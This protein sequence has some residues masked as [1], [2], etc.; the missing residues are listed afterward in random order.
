MKRRLCGYIAFILLLLS[1]TL[2]VPAIFV[3]SADT[4]APAVQWSKTYAGASATTVIQTSD[5]GY[6]IVS[7]PLIS[8]PDTVLEL[9][10]TDSSGNQVWLKTYPGFP[11]GVLAAQ[12]S[13]GGIA[14]AG[15]TS[16]SKLFLA[17]LDASGA[18]LWNTTFSDSDSDSFTRLILTGDGDFAI[19]GS[20]VNYD[21][22]SYSALLVKIDSGGNL[23]WN[24]TYG[25]T[26][27]ISPCGLSQTSDGGY[28][29]A[30]STQYFGFSLWLIKIDASGNTQWYMPFQGNR[31]GPEVTQIYGATA[32]GTSDSG[33]FLLSKISCIK[34][35]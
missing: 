18:I 13:D 11:G 15:T 9:I 4:T 31:M 23:L 10:K 22:D 17:R 3:Q 14:L 5:Q 27:E 16:G 20:T 21:T 24:Q 30:A 2:Y 19:L 33:Y 26:Q 12:T 1:V 34:P 29:I 25:G 6:L 8:S 28:V 7:S 35:T 32:L